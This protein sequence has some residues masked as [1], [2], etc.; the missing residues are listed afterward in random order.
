MK[1]IGIGEIDV[2]WPHF[3]TFLYSQYDDVYDNFDDFLK[4]AEERCNARSRIYKLNSL[5]K[6]YELYRSQNS[7]NFN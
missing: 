1:K 2:R 6:E 7:N 3:R 4:L 5:L